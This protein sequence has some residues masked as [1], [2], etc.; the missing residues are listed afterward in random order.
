M[1]RNDTVLLGDTNG[2]DRAIQQFFSGINTG[3]YLSMPVRVKG[4]DFYAAKDKTMAENA[5]HGFMIWNGKS[6]GT[7]SQATSGT[8]V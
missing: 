7:I 5:D 4:F 3:M 1:K 6:K 8:V 2:M